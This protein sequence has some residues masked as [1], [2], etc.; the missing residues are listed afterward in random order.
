MEIKSWPFWSRLKK[1]HFYVRLYN[2]NYLSK[3]IDGFDTLECG[4][5]V[6]IKYDAFPGE[7]IIATIISLYTICDSNNANISIF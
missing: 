5:N 7:L 2:Q 1:F 4:V 6:F 3:I